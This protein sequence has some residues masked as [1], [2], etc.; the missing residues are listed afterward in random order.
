MTD[1]H[2]S[3]QNYYGQELQQSSDLKTDACCSKAEIPLFIKDIL[4]KI[5]PDVIAKYYGCGLIFPPKLEG[6]RVL[7]LGCGAGRDV[8]ILSNLVGHQG[9]VVGVDMTK[10]QLDIANR[11]IDYHTKEFDFQTPNV[12][13][14][15]G[16]IEQLTDNPNLKV[17]SFDVVV[18][19]C[20]VNLSPDKKKVLQQVYEMLKP[21]GEFYFSDVYADRSV[22]EELRQNQ[23]LWGECLSGA[24]RESDLI[25][26]ALDIGF[27]RPILVTQQPICIN[28]QQLQDL[29]GDIKFTSCTYRLFKNKSIED[30]IISDNKNGTLVTYQTPIIHYENEFQFDQS[31]IFKDQPQYVNDE[32]T[33]MLRIS[34]YN[35]NFKFESVTHENEIPKS[36]KQ[37]SNCCCR[38][39]TC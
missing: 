2:K 35:D 17:N 12:E 18:S 23:I 10:E 16:K 26:D 22:P 13:F 29:L 1:I 25:S 27:T 3:V 15:L 19:N 6:C 4:K 39:G 14:H 9:Y 34:R 21:G 20:V 8:Y 33:K 7:D 37:V 38:Q 31:I 28:N 30:P 11:F 5:H 24:I 32:L 36:T